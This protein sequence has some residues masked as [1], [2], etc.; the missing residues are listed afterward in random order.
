MEFIHL[1]YAFSAARSAT[2]SL[3]S[4]FKIRKLPSFAKL[5]C[6]RAL[7]GLLTSGSKDL[8]IVS[9]FFPEGNFK[10]TVALAFIQAFPENCLKAQIQHESDR[11]EED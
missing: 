5:A 8:R 9:N 4:I 10:R 7:V 6:E 3:A 2:V 11:N 1:R